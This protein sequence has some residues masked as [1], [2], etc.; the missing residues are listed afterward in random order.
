[1]SNSWGSYPKIY[2]FG[3]KAIESLFLDPVII[4]EKVDGSQFSF[5]LIDGQVKCKSKNVMLHVEVPDSAGMFKEAVEVVNSLSDKLKEGWTYRAEYLKN[6]KHNSLAYDRIPKNHLIL[7]DV[8][9]GDQSYLS[10]EA[11]QE[12]AERLGL[13][14]VPLISTEK[15]SSLERFQELIDRVSILGG[16]KIE[17]VVVKNYFRWGVDGKALMGKYVAEGFRELNKQNHKEQR[18]GKNDILTIL[19]NRLRTEARWNKAVQH[20]KENGTLEESPTDI[21]RLLKEVGL[22]TKAECEEEIKEALFK[23]AWPQLSRRISAGLPEW[24]KDKLLKKQFAVTED[25][26]EENKE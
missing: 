18:P 2:N 6:P 8:N 11:K 9:D 10:Y 7:F 17:G 4:E 16:Q 15:V 19:T 12:E 25:E 13:E 21:G 23:W 5:G 14:I 26:V 3:H 1:M 20:L 24:Y 22:D